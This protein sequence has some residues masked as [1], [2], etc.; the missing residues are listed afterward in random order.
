MK[1]ALLVPVSSFIV[2]S[3]I[4]DLSPSNRAATLP[5]LVI[6]IFFLNF[7]SLA[8]CLSFGKTSQSV[9]VLLSLTSRATDKH[10]CYV[11]SPPAPNPFHSPLFL[12]GPC[13]TYKWWESITISWHNK[14]HLLLLANTPQQ[15]SWTLKHKYKLYVT[16]KIYLFIRFAQITGG[17]GK[18]ETL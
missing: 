9:S 10:S 4:T 1:D 5:A 15:K 14:Q 17:N 13:H 8:G 6:H 2:I 12:P 7:G 18:Q 3:M 16:F 11:P